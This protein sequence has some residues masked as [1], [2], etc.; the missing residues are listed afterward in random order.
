VPLSLVLIFTVAIVDKLIPA[1][2]GVYGRY[3][4]HLLANLIIGFGALEILRRRARQAR[5]AQEGEGGETAVSATTA[6]ADVAAS[7][8]H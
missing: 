4:I 7:A 2:A 5:Q 3:A 8:S 6:T 1:S